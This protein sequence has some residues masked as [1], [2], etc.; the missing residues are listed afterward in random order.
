MIILPLLV[1]SQASGVSSPSQIP[2]SPTRPLMTATGAPT[3]AAAVPP[4]P[5]VAKP[6]SKS[7]IELL[8]D[9][10]SGVGDFD[11][12]RWQRFL[13]QHRQTYPAT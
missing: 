10:D 6:E 7:V 8:K 11:I 13:P 3:T 2:E 5:E 4:A 1:S 9:I 12:A